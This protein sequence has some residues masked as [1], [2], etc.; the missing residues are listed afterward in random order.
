MVPGS[1]LVLM[2]GLAL[3][4]AAHVPMMANRCSR[5]VAFSAA[6]ALAAQPR[7]A[8]AEESKLTAAL[9]KARATL[10]DS[11]LALDAGDWDAVR[12]AVKQATTPLTL[13][14]YLGDSVKARI[15]ALGDAGAPLAADRMDLLR[16]LGIVDRY[17]YQRQSASQ[18]A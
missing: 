6:A 4:S 3:S 9:L 8:L 10:V 12:A 15:V 2:S 1:L 11:K 13:K 14:G 5:R 17:C 18:G 16:A 7:V